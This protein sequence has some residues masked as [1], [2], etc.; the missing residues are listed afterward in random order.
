MCQAPATGPTGIDMPSITMHAYVTETA[1][2]A[3]GLPGTAPVLAQASGAHQ[4]D[5]P[6]V[7]G[8]MPHH[9]KIRMKMLTVSTTLIG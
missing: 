5:T 3:A 4:A 9:P 8:P 1:P 2:L 6:S 7:I